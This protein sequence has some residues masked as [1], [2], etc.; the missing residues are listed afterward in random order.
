V[1]I[2]AE[3]TQA[4]PCHH[5]SKM[6]DLAPFV[7]SVIRDRVVVELK[8]ENEDLRQE[9]EALKLELHKRNPRRSVKVT[10]NHGKDI[11][12]DNELNLEILRKDN[13]LNLEV[14]RNNHWSNF[15]LFRCEAS[16]RREMTSS[17][18]FVG[19]SWLTLEL[20]IDGGSSSVRLQDLRS[21]HYKSYEYIKTKKT[22]DGAWKY[23]ATIEARDGDGLNLEINIFITPDEH[24]KLL[25]REQSVDF[26]PPAERE[27]NRYIVEQSWDQ[28]IPLSHL[29]ELCGEKDAGVDLSRWTC[30]FE[31]FERHLMV[32]YLPY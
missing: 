15:S 12:A 19:G 5:T 13:E 29:L 18:L 25:N 20:W 27:K 1:I 2:V 21:F 4:Y 7:A 23:M 3:S 26:L 10:Y 11:V 8:D 31:W 9:N 24:A 32:P 17:F 16:V 14:L 28:E 6:S 30:T 22:D